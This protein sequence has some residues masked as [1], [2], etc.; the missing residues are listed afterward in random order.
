MQTAMNLR[1]GRVVRGSGPGR[2]RLEVESSIAEKSQA[3]NTEEYL[4][5]KGERV[6]EELDRLVAPHHPELMVESMRYSVLGG[7]KRVRPALCIASCEMLGGTEDD[8][9]P[10]ACAVE[11][12]HTMSL[13]HDDLPA[14]D[15][16]DFRRGQPTNHSK[17]GVDFAILAGDALLAKSFEVVASSDH[18][19]R[20]LPPERTV[21]VLSELSNTAG[22]KGLVGG[23]ALDILTERGKF[24]TSVE[25]LEVIHERKTGRLLQA[26]VVCGAILAGASEDSL[27]RLTRYAQDLGLGFQ[28]IDDVLDVIS[29]SEQLGKTA[30][31]DDAAG[32]ATYPTLVGLER[33]KQIA[34]ELIADAKAQLQPYDETLA[35]PLLALADYITARKN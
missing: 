27:A 8:A 19:S 15:N 3:L 28:V 17:Y 2:R 24:T 5:R 16:D 14:M 22:S 35:A 30:G 23:Q 21:R 20:S 32:K 29:T 34:D 6:G 18:L 26:A 31:K 9:L 1:G 11:L 10:A 33:S 4:Q 12:M 7:G 25:Q 13:V